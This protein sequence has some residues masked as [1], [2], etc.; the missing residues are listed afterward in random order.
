MRN[1]H[2]L[3]CWARSFAEKLPE[4]LERAHLKVVVSTVGLPSLAEADEAE[5]PTQGRADR[6]VVGLVTAVQ[7][8]VVLATINDYPRAITPIV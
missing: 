5:G 8:L 1:V 2:V 3:C 4:D 6:E 7:V